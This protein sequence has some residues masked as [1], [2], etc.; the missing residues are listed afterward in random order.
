M[1]NQN[2]SEI[3]NRM[4]QLPEIYMAQFFANNGQ[5]IV[6]DSTYWNVLGTLWKGGGTV[7]Q[8]DLWLELFQ[9][10]RR[11]K[12]KLMKTRERRF[13]NKLPRVVTAYRAINNDSEINKA[14]SWTLSEDIAKRIFS[15]NGKREVVARRFSKEQVFAY[16]DRRN[17]QEILVN[18]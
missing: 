16:F 18:L 8:Q 2:D 7:V 6:D 9:A 10:K 1:A 4:M 15:Q 12:H 13:F 11:N 5:D 14:I 17:E 3:I